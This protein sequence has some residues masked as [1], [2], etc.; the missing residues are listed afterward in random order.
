[1]SASEDRLLLVP[2]F[3]V[4]G[5][6]VHPSRLEIEAD[7]QTRTLEPKVMG[8]LCHLAEQRGEPVSRRTLLE[9]GWPDTVVGDEVLT[10]C[11]SELRKAFGDNARAPSVVGTVPR[12]G[13]RLLAPVEWDK[14]APPG[15]REDRPPPAAPAEPETQAAPPPRH[16]LPPPAGSPPPRRLSA[17]AGVLALALAALLVAAGY[18]LADRQ[19]DAGAAAAEPL[20]VR[21]LT[22]SPGFEMEPAFSP[23]GDQ[24]AYVANTDTTS[25]LLIR[26][27][28]GAAEPL[29]A[30]TIRQMLQS[31]RWH[32]GGERLAYIA[33]DADEQDPEG[34]NCEIR[35][36][37][38][39]GGPERTV[40]PCPG[41][42]TRT[43]DWSAD[44]R[45]L[46]VGG[47]EAGTPALLLLDA[48]TGRVRPLSYA[49]PTGAVD[50][51]PRVSAGGE[52]ILFRR[53][54]GEEVASVCVLDVASGVVTTLATDTAMLAGHDW[55]PGGGVLY[56]SFQL[57]RARFL[58]LATADGAAK[59]QP[60][61]V[62]VVGA[63]ARPD[64]AGG[65]LVFERWRVDIGL[66]SFNPDR[67][68]V[69]EP[70]AASTAFDAY[71]QLSPD[72]SRVAFVSERSGSPQ[73][74]VA[75]RDGSRPQQATALDG[76]AYSPARWSPDGTRLAFTA[77]DRDGADVYVLDQIGPDLSARAPR[78]IA[79]PGS[80]ELHPAWSADGRWL[81]AGSDRSGQMEV[82]RLPLS[83]DGPGAPIT[84]GGGLMA[85]ASPDGQHLYL[86]RPDEPGVWQR[87]GEA[88][89][90][91]LILPG[92]RPLDLNH[93]VPTDNGVVW[94]EEDA[95]REVLRGSAPRA[96]RFFFPDE[97]TVY[98]LEWDARAEAGLVAHMGRR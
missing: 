12:V 87:L 32:P 63:A 14:A 68:G 42:L 61:P 89:E 35:T 5:H 3:Q 22:A 88:G 31:P 84:V 19:R 81:Y 29:R 86:L 36:V 74:W 8:V 92:L 50:T 82:W 9:V 2:P 17:S 73:V 91:A 70:F 52:R 95:G 23:T 56:V 49:V 41:G 90:D 69:L 47:H 13:Y 67:P 72:G 30:V 93:W 6:R 66:F 24:V 20:A 4:A 27:A 45:T 98:G 76:V 44:G 34:E 40:G 16:A 85:R 96:R 18:A 21:P 64:V 51:T 94:V 28:A 11:V 60:F 37:S 79:A 75:R 43:L 25:L 38:A 62:D 83:G 58:R 53:T 57:S 97:G 71:P 65:R 15:G 54:V 80:N 59:P 7:G 33:R 48:G 77:I 39:L 1:M 10:R 55:L 78:R 26:P 46:V